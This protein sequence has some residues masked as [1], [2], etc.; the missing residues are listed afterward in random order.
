[1]CENEIIVFHFE[2]GTVIWTCFTMNEQH[3]SI[4][5][6]LNYKIFDKKK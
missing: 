2:H 1:M 4:F 3:D 6:K 5:D